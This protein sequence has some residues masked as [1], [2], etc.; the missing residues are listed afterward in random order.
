MGCEKKPLMLFKYVLLERNAH[1]CTELITEHTGFRWM[2]GS[3][4][5]LFKKAKAILVF[6]NNDLW[7]QNDPRDSDQTLNISSMVNQNQNKPPSPAWVPFFSQLC[8]AVQS[9]FGPLSL[10][11]GLFAHS[12]PLFLPGEFLLIPFFS[13]SPSIP[14]FLVFTGT[15][16]VE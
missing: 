11:P 12:L 13:I 5:S 16:V 3:E 2:A 4:Y 8:S 7:L 1:L 9:Y 14:L 10:Q 15:R 6:K